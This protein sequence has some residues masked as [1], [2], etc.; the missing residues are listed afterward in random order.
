MIIYKIINLLNNK[1]YIGK[2][3]KNNPNYF[4][5]GLL[6]KRAILKHGK[7]NFKKEILE[8]CIS[9]TELNQKEIFWINNLNSISPNGYN[10]T[11]GG[12]GGNTI[13]MKNEN[14]KIEINEKKIKTR[15][16]KKLVNPDY[17]KR[18]ISDEQ[19]KKI[20]D[21]NKGKKHPN[22]KSPDHFTEEHKKKIS[23]SNKGRKLTDDQKKILSIS[24]TGQIMIDKTKLKISEKLKGNSNAKGYKHT[25]E[26]KK[27]ISKNRINMKSNKGY[28]WTDEQ[29]LRLKENRK[30]KNSK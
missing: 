1:I 11:I 25:E 19:K 15:E 18:K 3:E 29:K 23:D 7:E 9:T 5:S 10:L 28:K 6:I 21:Y 30:N 26:A 24:H 4:G 22:R 27:L 12:T 8:I 13:L 16:L 14:E 17:Y 2:D 20:S